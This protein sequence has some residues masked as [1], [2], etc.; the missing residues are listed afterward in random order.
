MMLYVFL[1][2]ACSCFS[3]FPILLVML[4]PLFV[5]LFFAV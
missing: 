2:F 4:S 1:L 3:Y 5:L